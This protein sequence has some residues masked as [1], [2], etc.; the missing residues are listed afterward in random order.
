V[1]CFNRIA[2]AGAALILAVMLVMPVGAAG[3][4]WAELNEALADINV[5]M[6]SDL[7]GALVAREAVINAQA[8][9]FFVSPERDLDA[10]YATLAAAKAEYV[11]ILESILTG[12]K[13][14]VVTLAT[15]V[16]EDCFAHYWAVAYAGYASLW[17]FALSALDADFTH[18]GDQYVTGTYLFKFMAEREWSAVDCGETAANP[19][20]SPEPSPA[21]G[22]PSL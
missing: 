21:K 8:A 19:N 2:G 14:G 16:I 10:L 12:A 9:L 13:A 3:S 4:Q 11:A 7:E 6:A 15:F 1:G 20:P 5:Q 18:I 17:D 22:S